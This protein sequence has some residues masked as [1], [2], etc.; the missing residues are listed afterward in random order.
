MALNITGP[1][2]T[3]LQNCSQSNSTQQNITGPL[4]VNLY[5]N[6]KQISPIKHPVLNSNWTLAGH[7]PHVVNG[8]LI[9]NAEN[10]LNK[11]VAVYIGKY[12]YYIE[13]ILISCYFLCMHKLNHIF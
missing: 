4:V 3:S 1:N 5:D 2:D 9:L 13:F 7:V 8:T 12:Y 6:T 10:K 11:H